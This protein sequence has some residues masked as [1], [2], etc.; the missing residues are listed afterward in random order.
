MLKR[1]VL[2]QEDDRRHGVEAKKKSV[3]SVFGLL[4][5]LVLISLVLSYQYR[6]VI[7]LEV[8]PISYKFEAMEKIVEGDREAAPAILVPYLVHKADDLREHARDLLIS[9]GKKSESAVARALSSTE[10][11]RSMKWQAADI[12]YD[13]D[14][15]SDSTLKA[16]IDARSDNH[17]LTK[18][19]CARLEAK[20]LRERVSP[21][22]VE[23]LRR[24][25][26]NQE[27]SVHRSQAL[28]ALVFC[29]RFHSENLPVF[30][31]L[32]A[33]D[34]DR[35]LKLELL[36]F[37]QKKSISHLGLTETLKQCAEEEDEAIQ[38]LAKSILSHSSDG[39]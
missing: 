23:I 25:L 26:L 18:L 10:W 37:I 19:Y 16:C 31:K 21:E 1:S 36:E 24:A 32:L 33:T 2:L 28:R 7:L 12:F 29:E 17:S 22:T 38:R 9:M 14:A 11:P 30:V 4:S 34:G 5:V 3:R 27:N 20:I 35:A 6:F 8:G 13:I 15:E 39:F